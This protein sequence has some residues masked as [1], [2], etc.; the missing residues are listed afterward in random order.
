[1]GS[2]S[3]YDREWDWNKPARD[4]DCEPDWDWDRHRCRQCMSKRGHACHR[5]GLLICAKCTD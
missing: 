2:E 1:M 3:E 4:L 5:Y